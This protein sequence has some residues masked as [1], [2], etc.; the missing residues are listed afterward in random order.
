MVQF[1][2]GQVTAELC[3]AVVTAIKQSTLACREALP[4]APVNTQLPGDFDGEEGNG[5]LG[6]A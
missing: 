3:S 5:G 6:R 1:G 4:S 2:E